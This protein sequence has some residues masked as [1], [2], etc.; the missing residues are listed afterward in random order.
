M[1]YSDKEVQDRLTEYLREQLQGKS[2]K[3]INFLAMLFDVKKKLNEDSTLLVDTAVREIVDPTVEAFEV[4]NEPEQ[5][6]KSY[7]TEEE[8]NDLNDSI[9]RELNIYQQIVE[10]ASKIVCA[11]NKNPISGADTVWMLPSIFNVSNKIY[12]EVKK[13]TQP[14]KRTNAPNVIQMKLIE[15]MH[16]FGNDTQVQVNTDYLSVRPPYHTIDENHPI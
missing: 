3:E 7:F 8:W 16:Q 13:Q 4:L 15:A 6:Q 11:E 14:N 9:N 2:G 1:T 12:E 10:G 5:E